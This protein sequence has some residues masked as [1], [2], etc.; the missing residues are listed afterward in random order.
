M[1]TETELKLRITPEDMGRL[2]RHALLK[3]H[4]VAKP[5]TRHLHNIYFDTPE[6]DLNRREM[7]L[8]LRL[9][10]GR[11]LQTLKGGGSIRGGLHQRN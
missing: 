10:G 3:T 2:K 5:V 6:L 1:T 4:Q 8:R 7:A 11:W 9:A